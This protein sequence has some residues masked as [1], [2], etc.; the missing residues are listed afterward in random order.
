M[1]DGSEIRL[2]MA[3]DHQMFLEGL[4]NMLSSTEGFAVLGAC[5]D[6]DTLLQLV[7]EHQPDVAIVDIS[8]PG[9]GPAGIVDALEAAGGGAKALALT[10]HLE[11]SY[12]RELLSHGMSG[13]VVKEA[14]FEE[15][16]HAIRAVAAGDQY[17][18]RAMLSE[19]DAGASLTERE[20]QCLSGAASGETAKMIANGLGISERTVRFHVSNACRKLGVQRRTQGIR[21]HFFFLQVAEGRVQT[22]EA[23]EVLEH[24]LDHFVHDIFRNV[25]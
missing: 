19:A 8:M 25:S 22:L 12:A 21:D 2:V 10:M 17:L 5:A 7:A 15:L 1:S 18:C 4:S 20:L 9:P 14:A 13:Y 3:D 23:V 11:P 16:A 24:G 6:G